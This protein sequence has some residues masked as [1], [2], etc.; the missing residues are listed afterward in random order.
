VTWSGLDLSDV[1]EMNFTQGESEVFELRSGDVLVAEASGSVSEV[2]K[3]ALWRGEIDNCC[4]QNT[5]LRVRSYGPLAE[6][7][8]YFLRAEALTGRLGDAARGVGIHHLGAARLS[9]WTIPLAPI[10]EQR[11]IVTAIEEHFSRLDAAEQLLERATRRLTALRDSVRGELLSGDWPT[12]TLGQL[13]DRITK[14]TTPT[15]LGFAFTDN[16]ILFV[17]AESLV[18]GLIDHARCAHIDEVAD[19]ALARSRLEENDI[20][21]TIAGT[22]GRVGKV[23]AGDLPAN[24]NQA[25]SVIRLKDRSLAHWLLVWLQGPAAQ[26]YLRRGGRGVGLQNLNLKQIAETPVRLPNVNEQASIAAEVERQLSIQ[27]AMSAEIARALRRSAALRR[28]ILEQAFRGELVSQDPSDEPA[29]VLLE[30]IAAERTKA[31]SATRRRP[32][33]R[34]TMKPS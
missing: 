9:S 11:R 4:F 24:T 26:Q 10:A 5:L 29:S 30:R 2:G 23:R 27:T 12:A 21:V 14:G 1:K 8:L 16:G 13:A 19:Q 20:L 15:S 18:D 32:R 17:K 22:L 28:S 6:Y 31:S 25:V 34:A 3:P 33:R 7:V